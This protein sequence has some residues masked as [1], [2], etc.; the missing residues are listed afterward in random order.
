MKLKLS[1]QQ[2]KSLI[3]YLF[4]T[5]WLIGILLFVAWPV[6]QSAI[7]AFNSVLMFP[8]GRVLEFVG[9]ENFIDIWIRDIYFVMR[10]LDFF[11]DTVLRVPIIVVI[12]LIIAILV[13]QKIKFQG[14]FRT[15]YFL[16]VIIASGPVMAE[17]IGTDASSIPLINSFQIYIFLQPFLPS[18]MVSSIVGLFDEII[19]I[20]WFSGIQILIFL[21]ALQKI[22]PSL[23]EAAKID[24]GSG[25]ECFWKITLPTI[26]PVILVN[27][28]YTLI[29][30]A[31]DS[32][33]T[34]IELIMLN[35]FDGRRGY[36]FATAMAW[37][38]TVIIALM[39][40]F[41]AL[42]F[43]EREDKKT[44]KIKKQQRKER[45]QERKTRRTIQRNDIKMKKYEKSTT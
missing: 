8:T 37:M 7:F 35:V 40:G 28:V 10:L 4:I 9:F 41:I 26:K 31:N 38:Y 21:A 11:V 1:L 22:S 44:R 3:G 30:L 20:L 42:F 43:I 12:A 34:V 25:W 17:L 19:M 2:R 14:F 13:N 15:V 36:G 45:R 32:N 39:L 24:G 33:N 6:V 18:W 16:P 27:L 23:Y 29:T 5:P